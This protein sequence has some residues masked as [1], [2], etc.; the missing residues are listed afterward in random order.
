MIGW[1]SDDF[2]CL[3]IA[4][5]CKAVDGMVYP[6]NR[7]AAALLVLLSPMSPTQHC[8]LPWLSGPC[9]VRQQVHV[10]SKV[11]G[12]LSQHRAGVRMDEP[13]IELL[14]LTLCFNP[15]PAGGTQGQWCLNEWPMGS[16]PDLAARLRLISEPNTTCQLHDVTVASFWSLTR[17]PFRC[18]LP[19]VPN[20]F[21]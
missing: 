2:S 11:S 15:L 7:Y 19:S 18:L 14:P 9:C 20:R 6:R 8:Q 21:K 16:L 12:L 13:C 3:G 1:V 5:V 4:R 10:C 17:A